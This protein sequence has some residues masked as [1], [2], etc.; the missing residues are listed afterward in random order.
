MTQVHSIQGRLSIVFLFLLLLVIVLG[1][2]SL[3]SLHYVNEASAQIRVRWLPGTRA[4]GDLNNLTT[5]YPAA[6]EQMLRAAT[7]SDLTMSRRKLALLD[8]GVAAAAEAYRQ[9]PLDEEEQRLLAGFERQWREY[10]GLVAAHTVGSD[11]AYEAASSLLARLTD[12]NAAGAREASERSGRVYHQARQRIVA[13]LF[14]A[15]L[16]VVGATV[17]VTRSISAPLLHLASGMHRL[18]ENETDIA[19]HGTSRHDEIGDMARA[20][21]V[22]RNNAIDLADNRR[23]L[24]QQTTMLQERLA[25][26]QRLTLLQRNFIAMARC[27]YV[28]T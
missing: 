14:L 24:A 4:L 11:G 2:E 3:R 26:E 23:A 18:A 27:K 22:F 20:V 12:R 25:E 17:H 28:N 7:A 19:V 5:D 15:G 16:L 8:R 13:M 21:V 6:D 10:R 9:I 1:L